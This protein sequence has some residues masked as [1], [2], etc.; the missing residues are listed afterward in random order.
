MSPRVEPQK[1]IRIF[2]VQTESWIRSALLIAFANGLPTNSTTSTIHLLDS[3]LLYM[4]IYLRQSQWPS[5]WGVCTSS[6]PMEQKSPIAGGA[7]LT[8]LE[9]GCWLLLLTF[10][11]ALSLWLKSHWVGYALSI[12]NKRWSKELKGILEPTRH[13][14]LSCNSDQL[15]IY[16]LLVIKQNCFFYLVPETVIVIQNGWRC[17]NS[18]INQVLPD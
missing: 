10:A 15:R 4:D 8:F 16:S 3:A 17:S 18:T 12:Q 7:N 1:F 14:G 2:T 13:H 6:V 9:V 11:N 5:I